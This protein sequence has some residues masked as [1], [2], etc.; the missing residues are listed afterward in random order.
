[1]AT[2][3]LAREIARLLI[4]SV[5]AVDAALACLRAARLPASVDC[6]L[7]EG[8]AFYALYPEGYAAPA[9]RFRWTAPPLVIGLRSIG[10]SLGATVAAATGGDLVT[11][12][13]VG[14]PFRREL[15][16]AP[17]LLGRF[18][19]HAGPFAIVDEG[20]GLSGSSFG[21]VADLLERL[22][23]APERIVFLPGH[24]GDLGPEASPEHRA[25]W[26]RATRLVAESPVSDEAVRT[27]FDG[28]AGRVRKV[29]DLSGGRWR[30]D[31][32]ES[33]WPPAAP[34]T[35]RLKFRL[36][37]DEGRTLARFVG[38]GRPGEEAL[39]T[40]RL[41][42][43]AGFAPE[44]LTLRRGFL[45][46]RWV[47]GAPLDPPS[48]ADPELRA[49]IAR[50]LG[51]R[52]GAMRAGGGAGATPRALAEMAVA[53]ATETAG[54]ELGAEVAA[55]VAELP[56]LTRLVPVRI[57]GRLHPWEWLRLADGALCKTDAL[58]HAMAHDLVGCQ[59][60]AWD[61]A[62]AAVEFGLSDQQM[63]E[64]RGG[65]EAEAGRQVN[66]FAVVAFR[67]CYAAF[68]AGLWAM[69]AA[70]SPEEAPR[71]E[72]QRARYL[73]ALRCACGRR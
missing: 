52:G 43:V 49:H 61:V 8:Y 71:A 47:E 16:L 57:D 18:R 26:R 35:E 45:L 33:A 17:R 60:I 25:R 14:P 20:P 69:A 55:R 38:L 10:T 54:P 62:G 28:V 59:D 46:E 22:G 44:P 21:A 41:L 29:E 5:G 50:Y 24:G 6:K 68:Q 31:L 2:L 15:A 23:V 3:R 72:R 42:H 30:H 9:R 32:A 1:M 36:E 58:D 67:L 27:W 34:A 66:P 7:P 12:R 53:N 63:L 70:A 73:A 48:G 39:D 37:T 56:H 65:V 11:V 40:A 4:G 13:P 19:R 64:L 51:F